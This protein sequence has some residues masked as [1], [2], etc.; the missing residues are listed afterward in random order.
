MSKFRKLRVPALAACMVCLSAIVAFAAGGLELELQLCE[1]PD[2]IGV[3]VAIENTSAKPA[4]GSVEAIFPG[5]DGEKLMV[6]VPFQVSGSHVTNLLI[7][8]PLGTITDDINPQSLSQ[9]SV[10]ILGGSDPVR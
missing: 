1:D 9:I 7:P 6:T 8:F 5:E 10:R 2:P 4:S 3:A